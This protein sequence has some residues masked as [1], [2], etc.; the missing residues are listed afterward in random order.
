MMRKKS[1]LL[2]YLLFLVLLATGCGGKDNPPEADTP[3]PAPL[4][5]TYTGD[6]GNLVFNGDGR[7]I[8]LNL[9]EEFAQATGLPAGE[10]EGEFVFLFQHGEW[11]YDLA[12]TMEITVD[13]TTVSLQ[14][15]HGSTDESQI[16]LLSPEEDSSQEIVF[17]KE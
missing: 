2:L 12:E 7:T 11:R 17:E 15:V 16:V 9:T 13:G 4:Q 10:S 6:Y 1:S 14:N 5:G 3:E 8:V